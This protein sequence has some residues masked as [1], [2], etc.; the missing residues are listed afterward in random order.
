VVGNAVLLF[1]LLL[2]WLGVLVVVAAILYVIA[3]LAGSRRP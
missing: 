2:P 1:G 3:R